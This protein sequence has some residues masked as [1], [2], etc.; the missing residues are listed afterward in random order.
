M[1]MYKLINHFVKMLK[2]KKKL[3]TLSHNRQPQIASLVQ[4]TI[5][6]SL[7]FIF[8]DN[9][10]QQILTFKMLEPANVWHFCSKHKCND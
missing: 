5:Q 8:T 1:C 2:K 4:Q 3:T 6:N 10:K 7:R 9:M